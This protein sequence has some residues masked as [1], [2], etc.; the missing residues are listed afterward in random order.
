MNTKDLEYLE[1]LILRDFLENSSCK[2][3]PEEWEKII[4]ESPWI[5]MKEDGMEMSKGMIELL[6]S[7]G[8]DE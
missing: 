5:K 8:H 7:L 3:T 1:D 2:F 4:E 6:Q